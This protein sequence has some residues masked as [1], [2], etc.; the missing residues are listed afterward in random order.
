MKKITGMEIEGET[1]GKVI[2]L[3]KTVAA[4]P[5][6][7]IVVSWFIID[8]AQKTHY[9]DYNEAIALKALITSAEVIGSIGGAIGQAGGIGGII[10]ALK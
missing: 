4:S 3:L 1:I 2:D 5:I 8:L 6:G 9:I 7:Q 10:G